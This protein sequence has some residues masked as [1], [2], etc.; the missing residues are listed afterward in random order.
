V[1]F[2]VFAI[3]TWNRQ[4]EVEICIRSI[5]EQ[6]KAQIRSVT[7]LVQDDCSTDGTRSS[8]EALQKEYPGII[9][10]RCTE[11]RTDYSAAFKSLFTAPSAEWV[12]TFGDDDLLE[13]GS[14]NRILPIL[15]ETDAQ[16]IHCVEKGR[17]SG[18]NRMFRGKLLALC[19]S[20]GWLDMTGFITGNIVR[21]EKLKQA[22]QSPHWKQYSK[23]AFVQSCALLEILKDEQ[24]ALI[25]VP[26]IRTQNASQTQEC[27]DRW[28]VDRIGERYMLVSDCLELMFEEGILENKLKKTFFRYQNYHLWDR[29]IT[30]FVSDYV[31]QGLMRPSSDWESQAKLAKFVDDELFATALVNE[32][33]MVRGLITLHSYMESNLL[34]I[35]A[36]IEAVSA[37]RGESSYPWGYV[38][39][40]ELQ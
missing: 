12:W 7:I 27:I 24:S 25:D 6:I 30:Y 23:S 37:R 34:G 29:H 20:F 13:P 36:E 14:L 16:F 32:I 1:T 21:G 15:T 40:R 38:I 26:L 3:P 31:G 8:I 5:A 18:S 39:P 35:K 2:L 22:A 10:Y 4:R 17:E 28:A 19:N 9:E 11:K 33:E